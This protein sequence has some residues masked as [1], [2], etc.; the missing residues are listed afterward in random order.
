M[1]GNKFMNNTILI[2]GAN[3]L[4]LPLIAK[5]NELG[6]DTLV[7]SPI[8]TEPG[9]A[10]ATY[11]EKC[12]V[13]DEEGVL[14]IARKYDICGIITDQ[15]DLP[16]RTMAYVANKMGLPGN[17][18]DVACVFTDKYLMREKCKEIGVKTVDYKLCHTVEQAQDFFINTKKAVILKPVDNQGSKG[19]SK[20]TTFDELQDKFDEA[21]RY[22]RS[23]GVLIEEFIEGREFLVE[24]IC[25]KYEYKNLCCGDTEYFNIPNVFSASKREFPS[26]AP[27]RIVD[28]VL[29]TNEKICRGFGLKQGITHAEY[30]MDGDDVILLEIAARGGGVFISSD[31]VHLQTGLKTEE[32]L[33]G[34]ATGSVDKIPDFSWKNRSC[35]YISFFL[36]QGI[37]VKT[38]GIQQVISL[39]YTYHNNFEFLTKGKVIKKNIDKTSRFFVIL[40]AENHKKLMERCDNIKKMI[41]IDVLDDNGIINGVIWE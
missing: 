11:S 12:D 39:P 30:I 20:V 6:F 13:V 32:F 2:L 34:I 1:K 22:S 27:K 38:E 7:V 8:V 25:V 3:I 14:M 19:V 41:K 21:I 15:T 35:C 10:I 24:G 33:L 28:K 31:L 23:A 37:I 4:Q 36:P 16:V 40:E 29:R 18:Y 17:D 9:H 5:A 26:V